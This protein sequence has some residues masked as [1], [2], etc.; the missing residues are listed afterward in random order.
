MKT[1]D[2]VEPGWTVAYDRYYLVPTMN[3][4][5]L[6]FVQM[7]EINNLNIYDQ[8]DSYMRNS[9]IRARMDTGNWSALMK[10]WKQVYNSVN[11]RVCHEDNVKSDTAMLHWLADVYTYWQWRYCVKS[12]DISKRCDARQLTQLYYPLHETSIQNACEK[13]HK[14][15]FNGEN[16]DED[17]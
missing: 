2:T 17:Q 4:I 6:V 12:A 11:L 8:I 1:L 15:F 3:L 13:L 9:E 14:R 10:G 5:R 7:N 16:K